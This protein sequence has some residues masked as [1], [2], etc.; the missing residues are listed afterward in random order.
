MGYDIEEFCG[1]TLK[2]YD[3]GGARELIH[4]EIPDP[5]IDYG[6]RYLEKTRR[7]ETLDLLL[8]LA[9]SYLAGKD[10]SDKIQAHHVRRAFDVI[11]RL[12]LDI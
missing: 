3:E 7:Y 5:W 8:R 1:H 4:A 11:S 10:N 2:D 9:S 12:W 6:D